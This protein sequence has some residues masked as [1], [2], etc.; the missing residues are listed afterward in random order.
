MTNQEMFDYVFWIA[1]MGFQP[2]AT[3]DG[4]LTMWSC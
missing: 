1:S 3:I 4:T 2:V